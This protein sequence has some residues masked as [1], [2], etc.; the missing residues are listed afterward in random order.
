MKNIMHI[1]FLSCQKA[2]ELIEKKFHFGLSFTD[3]MQLKAHKMMCSA[4]T[5]YEKQSLLIEKINSASHNK[6]LTE[7]DLAQ[8]KQTITQK[9]ENI[10]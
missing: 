10:K 9:L 7:N 6:E 1:L 5:N 3:K 4:C 8:L 2:T